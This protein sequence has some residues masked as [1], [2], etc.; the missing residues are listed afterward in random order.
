MLHG[1][2]GMTMLHGFEGMT[3]VFVLRSTVIPVVF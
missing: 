2:E 3:I 1:H